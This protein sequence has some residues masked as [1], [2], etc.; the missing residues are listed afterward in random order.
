M[1]RRLNHICLLQ[2]FF[3]AASAG[4]IAGGERLWD[5][6]G[7]GADESQPSSEGA[8]KIF[9][10]LF[11]DKNIVLTKQPVFPSLTS[12]LSAIRYRSVG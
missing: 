9:Q 12:S 3:I 6:L 5:E 7:C 2:G 8:S 11:V 1:R 10:S 4:V